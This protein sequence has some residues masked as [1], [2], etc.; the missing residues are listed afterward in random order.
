MTLTPKDI[1]S[2]QFATSFRGYNS[3]EVDTF[4]NQVLSDYE[5]LL[6]LNFELVDKNK[7]IVDQLSRYKEIEEMLNKTLMVAQ[8]TADS[9]KKNA[10]NEANH[11]IKEANINAD[12]IL[13]DAISRAQDVSKD[14]DDVK[15]Q[16]KLHKAKLKMML[17]EQL[18]MISAD[19]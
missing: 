14:L 4:L 5:K 6:R 11:I 10:K 1:Q 2:K 15:S 12:R 19:E 7:L 8:E 13:N 3:T 18:A 17:E 16:T 9:V